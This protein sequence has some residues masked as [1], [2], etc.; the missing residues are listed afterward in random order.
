MGK[1]QIKRPRKVVTLCLDAGLQAEWERATAE[2][3]AAQRGE[4]S[5]GRLGS[6][7][8]SVAARVREIEERM[9]GAEAHFVLEGLRRDVWAQKVAAHPPRDG[10]DQDRSLGVNVSSFFDDVLELS[11]A[12]VTQGG[13]PV[14]FDPAVDWGPLADE[15]TDGQYGQFVEAVLELNR[16]ATSVPFS[17]A[18]SRLSRDSSETSKPQSA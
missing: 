1:I 13:E 11:V 10:N 18:A 9:R 3:A 14:E 16:G 8:G 7:V 12:E 17:R 15:M 6:R 4:V 5:D 2:L